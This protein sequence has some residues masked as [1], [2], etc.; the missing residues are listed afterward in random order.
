MNEVIT[1]PLGKNLDNCTGCAAC[2]A[3]CA[4]ASIIMQE[5]AEGFLHPQINPKTCSDCNLCRTTCPVSRTCLSKDV[6]KEGFNRG[7]PISVFAAW[8]LDKTIRFESSSGGVFTAL[9]EIILAQG[10]VVVGAAFDDNLVV[11]HVLIETSKDLHRLRGS[12]YVQSV[13]DPTLYHQIHGLLKQGRPVLFSGT[14]CHIA[15]MRS[16]LGEPYDNLFCC[17]I[18]C[19]GVPSPTLFKRYVQVNLVRGVQLVDVTFRDK[20]N[21]WKH[22]GV[23]RHLNNG[24]SKL[25]AMS[26]D[27]YMAA[28][29][30]DYALRPSCYICQ[31]KSTLRS[32]DLTIAD[33]WGVVNKYPE[34]DNDD[35]GTSLVLVNNKHGQTWLDACRRYLFLGPADLDT[36]IA[37]NPPLVRPSHRPPERDTF[38]GDLDTLSFENL[39]RKYRL[40]PP[41]LYMRIL[42]AIKRRVKNM[43]SRVVS[44]T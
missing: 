3:V 5:D 20:T 12:K 1:H 43:A 32:S 9:A 14:P 27:P 19:H 17:D 2:A 31:F 42:N 44:T 15:A 30:R 10:G 24:S 16:Y 18:I 36:A 38:Y 7:A 13:I 37:G 39:I 29:L 41:L 21:G 25:V 11:R 26:A 33:F 23:R 35:K 6:Q 8:H 4:S 40:N 34:Y 22:F 28:F